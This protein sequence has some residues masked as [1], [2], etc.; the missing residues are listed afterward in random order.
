M[1]EH[2]YVKAIH[3]ALSPEVFKWKIHDTY[4]GGVPDTFYSGPKGFVWVEYKYIKKM[5]VQ[6]TTTLKNTLSA[7]QAVWLDRAVDHGQ[8]VIVV[9][10]FEDKA[11]ILENKE[12]NAAAPTK[13][14]FINNAI[15]RKEYINYLE[16][17][18]L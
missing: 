6:G 2:S 4:A 8:R 7:L 13:D 1:N 9:Y 16:T 10:G 14:Q 17:I 5:P 18:C 15:P 12:W 11:L 3:K